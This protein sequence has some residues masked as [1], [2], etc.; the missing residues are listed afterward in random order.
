MKNGKKVNDF[1]N[2]YNQSLTPAEEIASGAEGGYSWADTAQFD[3]L[4]NKPYKIGSQPNTKT[5][6][7]KGTK[8]GR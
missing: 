5:R 8:K 1:I 2:S 4:R 6:S 3:P 7:K